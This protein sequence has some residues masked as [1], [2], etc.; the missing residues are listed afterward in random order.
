MRMAL[1]GAIVG[2]VIT[3]VGVLW[4]WSGSAIIRATMPGL[5]GMIAFMFGLLALAIATVVRGP[6]RGTVVVSA[7]AAIAVSCLP[8]AGI[9]DLL[10]LPLGLG[11]FLSL[12]F[13]PAY[14][15]MMTIR[16][17]LRRQTIKL[18]PA[19]AARVELTRDHEG[20][21]AV[22]HPDGRVLARGQDAVRLLQAI[23]G[24]LIDHGLL[25]GGGSAGDTWPRDATAL[26]E[27]IQGLLPARTTIARRAHSLPMEVW[28][29]LLGLESEQCAVVADALVGVATLPRGGAVG[30]AA[31]G[32]PAVD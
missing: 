28:E 29:A 8:I 27:R 22:R 21:F 11:L 7:V 32:A 23:A 20:I 15:S 10:R 16:L 13:L 14:M 1:L 24:P 3:L 19:T 9:P 5:V 17:P 4:P 31:D 18:Y 6:G 26:G 2:P 12:L 30:P 25:W